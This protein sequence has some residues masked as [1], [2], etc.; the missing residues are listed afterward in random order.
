MVIV[1]TIKYMGKSYGL[2]DLM[3]FDDVAMVDQLFD[4]DKLNFNE[5]LAKAET[6]QEKLAL[7]KEVRNVTVPQRQFVGKMIDA[8]IQ[9]SPADRKRLTYLDAWVLFQML[10]QESTRVPE[11]LGQP[12][13]ATTTSDSIQLKTEPTS[14]TGS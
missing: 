10:Y 11:N 14:P 5:R 7:A 13:A 3:T 1:T 6:Q 2:K 12:S 9:M 8:Y 4:P